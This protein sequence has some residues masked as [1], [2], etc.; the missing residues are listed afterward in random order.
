MGKTDDLIVV[1]LPGSLR[2]GQQRTFLCALADR[3]KGYRPRVV[4]DCSHLQVVDRSALQLLLRCLE[5][6]M[7]R[8]GDARLAGLEPAA[9]T[10]LEETGA[11][12]LFRVFASNAE[13]IRS[14]FESAQGLA[15]REKEEADWHGQRQLV[16]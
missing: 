2:A 14:F 7:K 1:S 12:R 5:E 16:A 15:L 3:M 6:T 9:Q 8:N 10:T 4:I 11:S 13:A